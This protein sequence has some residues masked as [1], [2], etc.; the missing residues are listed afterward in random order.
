[1]P[2]KPTG[3]P[4]GRPKKHIDKEQFEK[5]CFLQCTL[6]EFEGFLDVDNKTLEKW[7]KDTYGMNFS[8]V[9]KLKRGNGKVSLRRK[10]WQLAE[11]NPTMAIWLGKQWLGQT[12]KQEVAVSVNDDETVKEMEQYFENRKKR[13]T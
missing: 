2:R 8:E 6:I 7:C 5:L 12:D 3:R 1:M 10:Q 13:N 4:N 11:T 9:Y